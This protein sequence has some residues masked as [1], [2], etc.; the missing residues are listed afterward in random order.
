MKTK[1]TLTDVAR[2]AGVSPMTVSRFMR[3]TNEV[4]VDTGELIARS[5][6]ELGYIPDRAAGRLAGASSRVI[7]AIV[8][9]LESSVFAETIRGL[10]EGAEAADFALLVGQ[11]DY[12]PAK[13]E[14]LVRTFLGWRPEGLVL[15]GSEHRRETRRMIAAASIPVVEVWDLP[16][17]P[18]DHAVGFSNEAASLELTS[19]L[20]AQGY[21]A[22]VF[23]SRD[24]EQRRLSQRRSGYERAMLAAGRE[25]RCLTARAELSPLAAGAAILV[26]LGPQQPVDLLICGS[27]LIALGALFECQRRGIAV[28]YD[29]AIA[30]FGAIEVGGSTVPS[31]TTVSFDSY[32]S[33]RLAAEIIA[34]PPTEPRRLDLGYEIIWRESTNR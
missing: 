17:V 9:T 19:G 10:S 14:R 20:L 21:G 27:D 1:V 8:P 28:P 7:A 5:V 30:G 34:E 32:R 16:D 4:S 13:E 12:D 24:V 25:P 26:E 22:P 6:A 18:I 11:S 2:H 33:G 29:V 15:V 3:S 31:L 23:V